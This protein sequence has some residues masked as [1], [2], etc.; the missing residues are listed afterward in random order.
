[1]WG[2]GSA[3]RQALPPGA[4]P[5]WEASSLILVLGVM[6][7]LLPE[8]AEGGDA[9]ARPDEDARMGG[10]LGEVEAASAEEDRRRG[11]Q[12]SDAPGPHT[13][14]VPGELG[15]WGAVVSWWRGQAAAI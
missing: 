10:V 14:W 6:E 15:L 7:L 4:P 8:T 3:P 2:C 11:G 13:H 12:P 1:M 5:T 9:C